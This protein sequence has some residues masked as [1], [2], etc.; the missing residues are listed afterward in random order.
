MARFWISSRQHL[1]AWS[2]VWRW[3]GLSSVI[4]SV[5]YLAQKKSYT[6]QEWSLPYI[7]VRVGRIR[8]VGSLTISCKIKREASAWC[9]WPGGA[10]GLRTLPWYRACTLLLRYFGYWVGKG[11]GTLC[12][13]CSHP[14]QCRRKRF[15]SW[16][17]QRKSAVERS[18]FV[19]AA[20]GDTYMDD[21]M[22]E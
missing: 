10:S 13:P 6:I 21:W 14:W 16:T 2:A 11:T 5:S 8:W 12:P 17:W 1:T 3:S 19:F 18:S 4:R 7:T 9:I 22:Y 15:S 20:D